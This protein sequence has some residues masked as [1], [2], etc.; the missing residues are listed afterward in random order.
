MSSTL[1][2]LR[3]WMFRLLMFEADAERFRAT[4]IRV[5]AD[6][7]ILEY[8]LLEETLAPFPIDMRNEAL[9]MAR[10][11]ALLYC[12][13]NSVRA[14][15]KEKLQEKHGADW[16]EKPVPAGVKKVAQQ[17][18]EDAEKETWL[19]GS[20]KELLGF[21]DFGDLADIMVANW[22]EFEDLI[23]TQHW[24]KQRMEELEKARNFIAHNR[25]LLPAEF[26]RIVMYIADWNRQ[27]G[28]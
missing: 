16:W 22:A 19:E 21:V 14:L 27:V 26:D 6:V 17:R 9:V 18:Q 10:L 23:P 15:I 1:K 7:R 28:L 20:K 24:L 11:H 2:D 5:G 25:L 3:D 8:S 12:F 13:E 4:G